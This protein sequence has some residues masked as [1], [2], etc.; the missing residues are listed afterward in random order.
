M[1]RI[2]ESLE[3]ALKS[4]GDKPPDTASAP[5]KKSYG[6]RISAAAAVAVASELRERG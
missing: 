6:E 2:D 4:V 1:A 3:A 5:V